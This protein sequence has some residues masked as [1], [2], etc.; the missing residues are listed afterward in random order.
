VLSKAIGESF[1]SRAPHV[2]II[3]LAAVGHRKGL[4]SSLLT[5]TV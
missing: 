2:V 1:A 5:Y 3:G 4:L